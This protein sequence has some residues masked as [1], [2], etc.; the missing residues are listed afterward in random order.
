MIYMIGFLLTFLM[1]IVII[2]IQI[3]EYENPKMGL[4][5]L[6]IWSLFLFIFFGG[7]LDFVYGIN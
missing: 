7:L 5:I 6:L 3:S 4:I 1:L 2:G